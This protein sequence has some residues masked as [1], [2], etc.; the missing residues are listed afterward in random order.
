MNY[1]SIPH[2]S[3][4]TSTTAPYGPLGQAASLMAPS[5]PYGSMPTMQVQV[6]QLQPHMSHSPLQYTSTSTPTGLPPQ[7]GSMP[8][9][10]LVQLPPTL[11]SIPTSTQMHPFQQPDPTPTWSLPAMLVTPPPHSP[12]WPPAPHRLLYPQAALLSVLRQYQLTMR[13]IPRRQH[14]LYLPFLPHPRR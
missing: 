14:P 8:T 1:Q 2:A 10:H 11:H 9:A 13:I 7:M 5:A 3:P 4:M 6:P 12:I